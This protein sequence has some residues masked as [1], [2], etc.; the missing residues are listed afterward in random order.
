MSNFFYPARLRTLSITFITTVIALSSVAG[1]LARAEDANTLAKIFARVEA[2]NEP[3]KAIGMLLSAAGSIQVPETTIVK[4][5]DKL[6]DITFSIDK[7]SLTSD[8]VATAIAYSESGDVYFAAVTPPVLSDTH[9]ALATIPECP[10]EDPT[11]IA[12]LNQLGPLQQLV[13]VRNERAKFARLRLERT[14]TTELRAR[15]K[16]AEQVFGLAAPQEFSSELPATELVDRLS[17]ISFALKNYR[18]FK[19]PQAS[20]SAVAQ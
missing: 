5:A 17:R 12:M 20:P 6:Y 13:D 1:S 4:V 18:A 15:L 19:K 16:K 7:S 11:K 14:L 9:A 2:K 10:A 3:K 8:T